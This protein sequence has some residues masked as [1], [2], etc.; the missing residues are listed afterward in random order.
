LLFFSV[1]TFVNSQELYARASLRAYDGLKIQTLPAD[2]GDSQKTKLKYPL[3]DSPETKTEPEGGIQ[4]KEPSNIN[5]EVEYNPETGK[6]EVRKKMGERVDYRP[7]T[8]LDFDEYLEMQKRKTMQDYW[9]ESRA[10]QSKSAEEEFD[11]KKADE[12]RPQLRVDGKTFDRIFGGNTV[13][14]KPSGSAEISLGGR[15][16]RNDNPV[17]PVRNRRLTTFQFDQNM[18]VNL[19]GSV[20]EKLKISINFNTQ[21][22]FDFQNQFKIEYT[23]YED[24][25]LQKVEL[26][27]VSLPLNSQLIT[28]S[29]S[30]FG[31]KT[32]MKFGYLE[33]TSV[34]SQ[35]RG[36]K[37]EI[38]TERG[39]QVS[40]FEVKADNYEADRH[41]FL[42]HFFRDQY[43]R[44]VSDPMVLQTSVNITKI[45]VWVT[46][47]RTDP[48]ARDI[49]AFQDLGTANDARIYR[50][51]S[52]VGPANFP[53]FA[54]PTFQG[55]DDNRS[56][57]LYST[58]IG[59]QGFD[60]NRS[61][62][63]AIPILQVKLGL[64]PRLDFQRVELARK[65]DPSEYVLNSQLGFI[66]LKQQIN[67]NQV[68]AVA[69][70]YTYRGQIY[71]V[72][73]FSTDL[74]EPR[75]LIL[76][77][78][79]STELNTHTPMWDLMMKNIYSIGAYRVKKEGFKFD[80]WYLDQRMGVD[81]NFLPQDEFND[82]SLVQLL[83]MD[84]L[85]FL[86]KPGQD[87]IF[88]FMPGITINADNGRII[89][90]RLEPFG[91][92]LRQA[93]I[94]EGLSQNRIDELMRLYGFDSLYRNTPI[95]ARNKYPERNRFS[96]KGQYQ[97]ES[98]SEISLNALNVPE[99]SVKVTAGG[100]Q[101]T[102]NQDYTVDY[103]LGRVKIIN[104]SI[105]ESGVPIKVQLESNQL[106]AQ[107]QKGF[108]GHRFDYKVNNDLQ[109]GATLLHLWEKPLTQ[110]VDIGYE[111]VS[112]WMYGFDAAYRTEIPVLT[113]VI[114]NIPLIDT[115]EMSSISARAEFAQLLPGHSRA[116]GKDGNS[117]IDDFEGSQ[118][119]ID[120]RSFSNWNLAATPQEQRDNFPEAELFNNRA[121]GFNRALLSWRVVDPL[122][123]QDQA[124]GN[125]KNDKTMLS[126]HFMRQI[127]ESE[128]FPQRQ[129]AAGT[130]TNISVLDLSLYPN[131]RGPYNYDLDGLDDNGQRW[132][133]GVNPD[134]TLA[135]PTTRWGGITRRIDQ[136]DWEA[137]NIEYIQFWMMDPFNEDY[138]GSGRGGKLYFNI[139]NISEDVATDGQNLFEQLLP[140]TDAEA[141]DIS[142]LTQSV[143]GRVTPGAPYAAGFDNDQGSRENQDVGLDGLKNAAEAG[144]FADYLSKAQTI[145]T[146]NA[147]ITALRADPSNDDY[148]Y[149]RDDDYDKAALDILERYK[150]FN[151]TEGNSPT[152][153]QYAQQNSEGYSTAASVQPDKEDIN[154]DNVVNPVEAYYQ[155]T[156]NIDP[157]AIAPENIGRNYI[158]DVLETYVTT[159]DGKKRQIRWYQFR[160]PVR[161][162]GR[163]R[164]GLITDLRTIRFIRMYM[165]GFDT[166]VHLR[167]ARLELVRGEWRRYLGQIDDNPEGLITDQE[168][169]F[170]VG[171]VNIEENSGKT[172]VNYV[173]P[174]DINREI[175]VTTT[176][177]Q[178]QNEQSLQLR[179]CGLED[180]MAKAAYRQTQLDLRMYGTLKMYVHAE[181]QAGQP[182][183][184]EG[185]VTVFIR[186]G[187]DFNQNY[188]E[189]EIPVKIT[190]DGAY[191]PDYESDQ[192]KVWPDQNN[193]ELPLKQWTSLKTDR[194]KF[195]GD[196][197]NDLA[198]KSRYER[199]Y[200]DGKIYVV[201]NPNLGEVK[202]I[203]IGIRNPRA[204]PNGSDD[205]LPKC[206]EVWV[207]ELRLSD[208]NK[209]KGWAT[210]GQANL[211]LA[212]LANVSVAAG[213]STPG[214]GS[215]DKKVSDRQK[216]TRQNVDV[217]ASVNLHKVLPEKWGVKVPM[218]AGYSAD[219]KSP[220][221]APIAPDIEFKE[222]INA[223]ETKAERDSVRKVMQDR[224]IRKSVNFT[225]VRKERTNTER[226]PLPTDI[227]NF[228]GTYAYSV[229]DQTT[230]EIAKN[231][232]KNHKVGLAYAY[233]L[234][235]KPVKPLSKVAL[236]RES[237]YLKLAR[238]FNFYYLP[239]SI[240]FNNTF[241]RF[242]NTYQVRNNNPGIT[243]RLPEFYNKN[244]TWSRDFNVRY[245][246]TKN[247]NFDLRGGTEARLLEEPDSVS[248]QELQKSGGRVPDWKKNV[249]ES[250]LTGGD[251]MSY[252]QSLNMTY[253]VPLDMIPATNWITS[254]VRYG[255]TYQWQRAPIL[256][257]TLGHTVQNGNQVSINGNLNMRTLY[258]KSNYLKQVQ[259]RKRQHQLAKSR[260]KAKKPK[261]IDKNAEG[262]AAEDANKKTKDTYTLTD[263]FAS[264]LMSITNATATYSRGRGLILPGF[265]ERA[266]FMGM[267]SDFSAPGV[268]FMVGQ[269]GNFEGK[270]YWEY[271]AEQDWL[272]RN[273][274][275]NNLVNQTYTQSIN[276][277]LT[278][279]PITDLR[280]T[281]T[282]T[283]NRS[284]NTAFFYRYTLDSLNP[285]A[286]GNWVQESPV[287]TGAYSISFFAMRTLFVKNDKVT[288][289]SAT[290]ENVLDN[291][292]I[293]SARLAQTYT[294]SSG[295]HPLYAGYA[296]GLGPSNADVLIPSF[297]AAYQGKSA[298]NT[299]LS[300]FDMLPLPNWRATYNGLT[301]IAFFKKY[302]RSITV[303][304]GYTSTLNVGGFV[305]NQR[306]QDVDALAAISETLIDLDLDSNFIT[307]YQYN[308]ISINE[309]FSPLINFDMQMLNKIQAR[310]EIRRGRNI[311]LNV[312]NQ[313]ITEQTTIQYTIGAGYAFP[314][315]L[316]FEI[317]GKRLNSD[318]KLR[319]DVSLRNNKSMVRKISDN[320]HTPNSGQNVLSFKLTGDYAVTQ[321][322][323]VRLFYDYVLNIPVISNT[324]KTANTNFGVSIRFSI[325]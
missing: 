82:R 209:Q 2:S 320:T 168:T 147:A 23:G 204:T 64:D 287:E 250:I 96:L 309:D 301:K 116:I 45:E 189:Y 300:V 21:A 5:T 69:F 197:Y 219:L 32:K 58:V 112:N 200:E 158:N 202:T 76:K 203:M 4:L 134:G 304:H 157:N 50:N 11:E 179:V 44:A 22:T 282:A 71:Q 30:L 150:R 63:I 195:I 199:A 252:N 102:E 46:N 19:L 190:P 269:Q 322:L 319:G 246:L 196:E 39:A 182:A 60:K 7:P 308:S 162:E 294:A 206:A 216:D 153:A 85:T 281:L 310:F 59:P 49:L 91:N 36:Q 239:K 244:F 227:S 230:F 270:D 154:N 228:S 262:Q 140:K 121:K 108:M 20:G 120:L 155:Y 128:V 211:K 292:Q 62:E 8:Y 258:T 167:F 98:S 220:M 325:A 248:N 187:S 185:D 78:L 194:N 275:I 268:G 133:A 73:E 170:V 235:P 79:K 255:A 188:Y 159:E 276:L 191:T 101:L 184:N 146:D 217:A 55:I 222:Y 93:F 123:F 48:N 10:K 163:T 129:L 99:G 24:E 288:N 110:K 171:A 165:K 26:G 213:M 95:D 27:N 145:I 290:F 245:D 68:L 254:N 299:P 164:H 234:Q 151:G 119:T 47:T 105:I 265:G 247:L 6:Y 124:P 181:S 97:S 178:Q 303:N 210:A 225:N 51:L 173:L 152:E 205:G 286:P 279:E 12:F 311:G 149:F 186:M 118:N 80:V 289:S 237:D 160:I 240:A 137:A 192:R 284:L 35:D 18:Q 9:K 86:G 84:K 298:E 302:F 117:Y 277:S 296:E 70:E 141:A 122:F 125:V 253:N 229:E 224:T 241:N 113:R 264:F 135:D 100:R 285:D 321:N 314:L 142:N 114:D 37:S 198:L 215:I 267:N 313:Q 67:S 75:P 34:L 273:N 226:K 17:I 272:V 144:F 132:A 15:I 295:A 218:Y 233:N 212:D 1:L 148:N 176:N 291:R 175:N 180:G 54:N 130:P 238:E 127:F 61:M 31:I 207:N 324:F 274:Y 214:F 293:I 243:A 236:L 177:Q 221:F 193:I 38:T 115:K 161:D 83:G 52:T 77:M 106:F 72:G 107:Q 89:I 90:P 280:V 136:N 307:K 232:T 57:N 74:A 259:Q 317:K 260:Q 3:K 169:D 174:P 156:V 111:P 104:Q 138:S 16:S 14:I 81:I 263:R 271:A 266:R 13:D 139:G 283:Q 33:I 25:I 56:N 208:F 131:E 40:K 183:L 256:R 261:E 323:N 166:P 88:D 257:D 201:G 278:S 172:P 306:Y 318:L 109:F 315:P 223:F 249:R 29:Q 231:E 41:Y 92:G 103:T 143:W 305:N 53:I 28:G 42:S 126:N 87:G 94:D 43:E 66:S 312:G 316:P 65:L 251:V 297:I 242:F